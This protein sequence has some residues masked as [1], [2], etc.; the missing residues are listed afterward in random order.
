MRIG[1][2]L[3]R[4]LQRNAGVALPVL[5]SLRRSAWDARQVVAAG[6]D[7]YGTFPEERLTGPVFL[8]VAPGIGARYDLY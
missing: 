6:P 2:P 7:G 5:V 1:L 8:T 3:G 4:H